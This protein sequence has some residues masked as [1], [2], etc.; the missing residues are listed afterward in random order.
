M[1]GLTLACVI[2]GAA[3]S[4]AARAQT[5][6]VDRSAAQAL[7]DEA[8]RLTAAQRWTEACPKL[9]ESQRLDPSMGTQFYLAEC[10][11]RTGRVATA[12]THYLEVA[13]AARAAGRRDREQHART[14]AAAL[15]ARLPRLVVRVSAEASRT[16][17]LVVTRDGVALGDAQWAAPIPVDPGEHTIEASARGKQR[18][19]STV[20]VRE[21]AAIEVVVPS[22]LDERTAI[23]PP[24][25]ET[26]RSPLH[27]AGI[28][29][30]A[31]GLAGIAV[32]TGFGIAAI[33]RKNASNADGHCDA[34]NT[35]DAVGKGLRRD[36]LGAATASTVAFVVGSAAIAGGAILLFAPLDRDRGRRPVA[37][38]A[39][40]LGPGSLSLE[41]S[42]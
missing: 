24:T 26:S 22:L 42:W 36:S 34:A 8:R 9:A 23:E 41:G 30:G 14:R 4:S 11:E 16:P 10:M 25:K 20:Q 35:C 31:V 3:L 19:T 28:V 1:T 39:L 13:D 2:T 18:W 29:S 33:V 15:E 40:G 21:G 32:G 37:T 27:I 12:W 6:S 38:L 17:G 7:F 5:S